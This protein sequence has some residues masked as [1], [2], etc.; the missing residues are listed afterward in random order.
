MKLDANQEISH[1]MAHYLLAIHKLKETRGFARVTDIAKYLKITKGSVSTALKGLRER[2]LAQ[3]EEDCKFLKLT[4]KGREEVLRILST[5]ILIFH[6]LRD[7][8]GVSE[9]NAARE[10]C[11]TEHILGKETCEK[12][13]QY[14]KKISNSEKKKDLSAWPNANINLSNLEISIQ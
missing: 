6:F 4:A 14:I 5:R 9:K 10:S 13:L 1:T 8:I 2:G 3:E 12:I 11:L 7:I